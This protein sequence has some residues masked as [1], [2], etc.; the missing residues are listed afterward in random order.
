MHELSLCQDLLEQVTAIA[1]THKA[2]NVVRVIVWIGPLS[3]V[4]P[5]LLKS[6]FDMI[7]LGTVAEQAELSL[8]VQAITVGCLDCTK[9]SEATVNNLVCRH[10]GSMNTRLLSGDELILA[11]VELEGVA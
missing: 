7:C 4:E 10:C 8:D 3:G 1:K 11:R 2:D 9:E 5:E 6:A